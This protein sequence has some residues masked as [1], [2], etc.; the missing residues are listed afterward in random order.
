MTA[1]IQLQVRVGFF[2]QDFSVP[3]VGIAFVAKLLVLFV[4]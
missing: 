1:M 4:A 3:V 2:P